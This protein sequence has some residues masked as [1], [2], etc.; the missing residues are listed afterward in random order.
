MCYGWFVTNMR[1]RGD[2]LGFYS[3]LSKWVNNRSN[4]ALNIIVMA[5]PA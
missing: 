2:D 3:Q 1:S 5:Q 4:V